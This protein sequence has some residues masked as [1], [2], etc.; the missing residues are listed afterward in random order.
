MVP[1]MSRGVRGVATAMHRARL[2]G[3]LSRA[4]GY[5][6]RAPVFPIVTYHRVNDD[7]DPF[8]EALA[9][10]VFEQQVGWIAR[11]Y[12][13]FT[14][15]ELVARMNRGAVPRN[16]V[17]ITFDDGYRD[18]L[19]H[20]AP[21]LARH[22][23]PATIFL[24]TAFI[25]A[26]EV[27]WYDRVALAFKTT[28]RPAWPAPGGTVMPLGSLAER[29]RATERTLVALKQRADDER[30][31]L[32]DGLE[33][34]LGGADPRGLKNLMLSWDDVHALAGLG[35]SIGGH[36]VSHPIL[37]RVTRGAGVGRDLGLPRRDRVGDRP[38]APSL[39]VPQRRRRRLHPGRGRSR[40]A[41]GLHLRGDDALR[42]Q[43]RGHRSVAAP[44]GGT[45]G[46]APAD[47][48]AQARLVP[49][50]PAPRRARMRGSPRPGSAD[51]NI[52]TLPPSS[53]DNPYYRLFYGALRAHGV[54]PSR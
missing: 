15:E 3:A 41:G 2:T 46:G 53:W 21:I 40:A 17:A 18:N 25:G 6:R 32:V 43:Q 27:P 4:V 16:A 10:D 26:T 8:F 31:R 45:V 33:A 19:T 11:H 28:R 22:G 50:G 5:A 1:G 14:I 39:R 29:V 36:T 13:V 35:F 47:L 54:S 52:A 42:G 20:A 49:P 30:R 38:G 24:A 23:V 44:A 51:M 7:G 37:S 48:C 9:T 12:R 34:S